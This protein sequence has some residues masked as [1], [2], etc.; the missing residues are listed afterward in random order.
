MYYTY[1]VY[2]CIYAECGEANYIGKA[3]TKFPY[4][5]NNN[6]SKDRAFRKVNRKI[7]HKHF[8]DHYCLDDHLGI[9]D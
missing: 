1:L 8:H 4:R 7:L 3:K 2:I 5:F 6:K 9:D